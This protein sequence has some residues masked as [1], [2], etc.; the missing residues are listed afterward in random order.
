MQSQEKKPAEDEVEVEAART[1]WLKR[2]QLIN[3]IDPSFLA[4]TAFSQESS[5]DEKRVVNRL[6]TLA[7]SHLCLFLTIVECEHVEVASAVTR[8][9]A[10]ADDRV[11]FTG[12]GKYQGVATAQFH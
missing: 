10:V 2:K 3:R 9:L 6:Q 5:T 4:S 7:H 12:T 8:L 11:I 1:D